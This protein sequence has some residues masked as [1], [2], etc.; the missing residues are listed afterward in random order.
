MRITN[1]GNVCIGTTTPGNYKLKVNGD[2]KVKKLVVSQVGWPDY[3]FK[4]LEQV[5]SFIKKNKHLPDIPSTKEVTEKGI[6]VGDTQALLLK[7]IEELTLYII[8]QHKQIE[9]LKKEVG[10]LKSKK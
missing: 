2:V 6:S 8:D 1:Q 10:S 4:P 3:V 9:V 7:K 5:A